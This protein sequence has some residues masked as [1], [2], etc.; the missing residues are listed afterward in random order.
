M[1]YD[2][3]DSPPRRWFAGRA[4][5]EKA[6]QCVDAKAGPP[7][8]CFRDL[9]DLFEAKLN[10]L[11][12]FRAAFLLAPDNN[13]TLGTM[14]EE[15]KPQMTDPGFRK[16]A[17]VFQTKYKVSYGGTGQYNVPNFD[18][19]DRGTQERAAATQPSSPVFERL[20]RQ[21]FDERLTHLQVLFAC[22]IELF[23]EE[24]YCKD[25]RYDMFSGGITEWMDDRAAYAMIARRGLADSPEDAA[26][27]YPNYGDG[28]DEQITRMFN[29]YVIDEYRIRH[30]AHFFWH[31]LESDSIFHG[32]SD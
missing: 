16:L 7:A 21:A 25:K 28:T 15:L 24:I 26:R 3:N 31:S 2:P 17:A 12:G 8:I 14:L 32:V 18:L 4:Y 13:K 9:I 29:D 6:K 30:D 11:R 10:V 5:L 19:V 27:K 22:A 1:G 20:L 23:F